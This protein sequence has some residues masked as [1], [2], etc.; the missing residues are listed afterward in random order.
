MRFSCEKSVLN[1]AISTCLH[2]VSARSSSQILE[3]LLISAEDRV[4]M[5][6]YNYKIGIKK[7]FD[8]SVYEKGVIV[9]D[10][11]LLSDIVRKMPDKIIEISVDDKLT[12]TIKCGASCF[13]IIGSPAAE[14]PELPEIS[15]SEG[16]N[17]SCELL[18]NM[19]TATVF[20]VSDNENKPIHTGT[21]FEIEGGCLSMVSVDGFRLAI[22]KEAIIINGGQNASFVV[23]GDALKELSRI[24][25]EKE[26]T[27]CSIYPDR[28][29]VLF[30]FEDTVVISRLLEGEF[31][32][33]KAAIPKDHPIC[34]KINR[35]ELVSSIELV[36]VIISERFK[37]SVRCVFDGPVLKLSCST[38]RGRSY[39]ECSIPECPEKIE[40]GF[41]NR[42]LLD[43]LRASPDEEILL[44]LSSGLS[45]CNIRPVEGDSYLYMVLPVRLKAG[46]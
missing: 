26:D 23:P 15:K 37:N 2:A 41:N 40:I 1:D 17:L 32:N 14:Y 6:G 9:I 16:L 34:L 30:E 31:L 43:A 12:V 4:V 39:E 3:G 8:A 33:Y 20:A 21:L 13:T 29:Q 25:P 28:R 24:L 44:D 11:R 45:P 10:A 18:K 38:V 42:Y 27:V 36:S 22:R 46:E 35:A 7:T 5:S 19:I